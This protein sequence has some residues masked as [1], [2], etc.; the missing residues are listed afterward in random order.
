MTRRNSGQHRWIQADPAFAAGAPFH[1]LPEASSSF[2][3]L[4]GLGG[5]AFAGDDDVAD[6]EVVQ[7]VVDAGFAVAAVGGYGP[8][9]APGPSD[10]AFDGGPQLGWV[11]G[12]AGLDVVVEHDPVSV[13][14]HLRFVAE[15]D[16]L[17]EPA[18]R[19]RAGVGV[20]QTDPPGRPIGN[21][22]GTAAAGSGRRSGG[23][24]RAAQ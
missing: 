8:R 9:L 4:S 7:G 13:V 22:A 20:V 24:R 14:T 19:D 16:R 18:L 21:A 17:A 1:G 12:V 6:T 2:L 3:G 23:S 5:S 15:L 10:N 11:G